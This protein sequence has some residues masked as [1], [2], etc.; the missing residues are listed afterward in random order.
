[1]LGTAQGHRKLYSLRSF[2]SWRCGSKTI[3]H[4][5]VNASI[6]EIIGLAGID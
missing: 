5:I 2:S 1:M 6:R 4:P 3:A